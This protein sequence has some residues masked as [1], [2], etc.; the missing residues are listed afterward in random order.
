MHTVSQVIVMLQ[1][2]DRPG[3][4]CRI[5]NL[6]QARQVYEDFDVDAAL[7]GSELGADTV[8]LIRGAEY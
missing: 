8:Y 1:A 4:Y 5:A 3:A 6:G 2:L 7:P